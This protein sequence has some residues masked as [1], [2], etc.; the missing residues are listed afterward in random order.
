MKKNIVLMKMGEQAGG[1]KYI[2]TH[3]MRFFFL[4]GAGAIPWTSCAVSHGDRFR[5]F[6]MTEKMQAPALS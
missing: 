6:V 1:V 2:S 4:G 5:I 3:L